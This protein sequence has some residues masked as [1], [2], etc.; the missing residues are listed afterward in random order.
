M[1]LL[2]HCTIE[3]F[4]SVV[5]VGTIIIIGTVLMFDDK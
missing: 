4:L 5:T 1:N 3:L 2:H